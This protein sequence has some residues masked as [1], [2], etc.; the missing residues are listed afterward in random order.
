MGLK[1]DEFDLIYTYKQT[2]KGYSDMHDD[3]RP[4]YHVQNNWLV[5]CR[6]IASL[7]SVAGHN[8]I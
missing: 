2:K 3:L 7:I 6:H 1:F 5:H 4:I 8:K